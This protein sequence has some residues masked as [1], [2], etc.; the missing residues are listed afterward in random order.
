[1]RF[2]QE[3]VIATVNGK[4][5]KLVEQFTY[6]GSNISSTEIDVNI[7][8]EKVRIAIEKLSI[9]WK[10]DLSDKIKWDFFQVVAVLILLYGCTTHTKRKI[11]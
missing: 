8:Q 1:M 6:L 11:F 2:K 10:S 3:E 4:F 7:H 5:L 9:I